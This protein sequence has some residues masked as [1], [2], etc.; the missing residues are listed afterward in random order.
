MDGYLV[1]LQS[2]T[3]GKDPGRSPGF[4][5]Q[6]DAAGILP[7]ILHPLCLGKTGQ[8]PAGVG[9]A[10][11]AEPGVVMRFDTLSACLPASLPR[12]RTTKPNVATAAR[13]FIPDW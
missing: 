11:H 10:I 5:R 9:S 4:G 6:C 7:A 3:Q 8:R 12:L 1:G 2:R 13:T